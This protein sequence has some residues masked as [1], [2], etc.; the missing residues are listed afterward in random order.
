MQTTK[1]NLNEKL[2]ISEKGRKHCGKSRKGW[3]PAFSPFPTMFLK[4]FSFRVIESR[5]HVVKS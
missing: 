1:I 5:D 4:A 2:K 3:L